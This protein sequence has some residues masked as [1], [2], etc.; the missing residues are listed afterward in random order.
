MLTAQPGLL[1]STSPTVAG[2]ST[3]TITLAAGE[4]NNTN[5]PFYI[6]AVG[7]N[8]GNT[9]TVTAQA[10]GYRSGT[11]N[12][13]IVSSAA[14]VFG[15]GFGQSAGV[16]VTVTHGTTATLTLYMTVLNGSGQPYDHQALAGGQSVMVT[17]NNTNP[18]AGTVTPANPVHITGGT[19]GV[20]LTF[21]AAAG[22]AG[23]STMVSASGG[24]SPPV[25]VNVN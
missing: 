2:T 17:I 16:P 13:T 9:Y 11:G 21:N 1:L 18:S 3:L 6:Q 14:F 10:A 8:A 20:A 15:N 19:D 25:T 4:A 12:Q 22:G 23:Q 5:E 24:A 7:G